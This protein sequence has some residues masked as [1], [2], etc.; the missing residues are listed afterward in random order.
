MLLNQRF[1]F[2]FML[3][4]MAFL[5]K[6][7]A[8]EVD[9]VALTFAYPALGQVYV[10]SVFRGDQPLLPLS[11]LLSMFLMVHDKN[12]KNYGFAGY[13]PNKEDF[14]NVDPV[15]LVYSK[16]GNLKKLNA[17]DVYIGETDI[18]L[19]PDIY[20]DLFDFK[21]TVNPYALTLSLEKSRLLPIEEYRK[22][23]EIRKELKNQAPENV[24][25][26]Y[27][28]LY[29]RRRAVFAPGML[30]YNVGINTGEGEDARFTQYT[31]SMNAGIEFLGGDV[32]GGYSG[33]INSTD[34]DLNGTV[35]ALRWRYVFKNGTNPNISPIISDLNVGQINLAGPYATR[36]RG[37]SVSNNPLVP[38]RVLDI[39]VIEGFTVPDSEIELLIGGQLVDFTRADEVGYYRFNTPLTYGNVRVGIRIYT[40][41]GEVLF[42]DRQLQIPF[43]FVPRGTLTYNLQAGFEEAERQVSDRL[44]AHADI[45]YGLSNNVTLRLGATQL[46]TGPSI[47]PLPYGGASIRVFDQYLFDVEMQPGKFTRMSGGVMYSNNTSIN[48]QF[49]RFEGNSPLNLQGQQQTLNLNYFLPVSIAKRASGLRFGLD[50]N[51]FSDGFTLNYQMDLN[52]RFGPLIT[53]LNYRE[54]I[55]NRRELVKDPNR[56]ATAVVTYTIPRKPGLPVFVRGMFFRAS[57]RHDMKRF[58]ASALGSI[59]FSQTVF[60]KGRFTMG[61]DR[62]LLNKTN[63]LQIGLLY[64]FNALRSASQVALRQRN[65]NVTGSLSQTFSG[66]VG[67]DLRHG[68]IVPTNRDQVGRSGV[69]I[70]MFVDENSNGE[71]DKGEVLV[72]SKSIRLDQ[73]ASI[74]IGSDGM[75]RITQL[76]SYWTYRL[77]VDLNSLPD[78][79]LMPL[80]KKFSF[81]ADPNRFKLIDIPLYRTGIIE[82]FAYAERGGVVQAQPGLRIIVHRV[83]DDEPIPVVRTF[84]DGG[85]YAQGLIPGE[86]SMVVDSTQLKF[87]GMRQYPDTLRFTIRTLPEGDWIDT[88]KIYLK[89]AQPDSSKQDEILTLAQLE[90]ILAKKLR[91]AVQAFSEA[92]ELFYRGRFEQAMVMTDSSLREY[93]TDFAVAMKGSIAFMQG[94]KQAASNLWAAA[95][96]RNPFVA[97]PDTGKIRI[98]TAVTLPD[99][100]VAVPKPIGPSDTIAPLSDSAIFE[101]ELALG[102]Q[103]RN[104]VTF[105]TEAQEKFYRLNFNDALSSIDSSLSYFESDH[106]LALKGSIVY[107]L[108]RKTEAW[109]YWYEAQA[110]NPLIQ[111]PDINLLDRLT[112]PIAEAPERNARKRLISNPN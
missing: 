3:T 80:K 6:L 11:E 51:W 110:R 92:Q 37:F 2:A 109:Q 101:L 62:D 15:S 12:S 100:L 90:D 82:G 30:D 58:D 94:D 64:D 24:L 79:N 1:F 103:L 16:K 71:F 19:S 52:A 59:Q 33:S 47:N 56:L 8:Q 112:T 21:F 31:F 45:S 73:S 76:Q 81:V 26:E 34:R 75:L 67:A 91:T 36:V 40:P 61:F 102:E 44:S 38:R 106:A 65:N 88:L 17:N 108:G 20:L 96:E 13:Y 41:Q 39:F 89:P 22:R 9:E 10:S 53:R 28:L 72:P 84:S 54:E 77:S 29:P 49:I 104:S 105:F 7:R 68:V 35:S 5:P 48:A 107:I 46:P 93:T 69:T 95:R 83:G 25:K 32:Q 70:R 66:S 97:M 78:P 57:I 23:Q 60:K 85:F 74:L 27:P 4:C 55:Q 50:R 43:T 86:Y 18:F 14:W 63:T 111:L 98:K 99:S 87:M 42:E